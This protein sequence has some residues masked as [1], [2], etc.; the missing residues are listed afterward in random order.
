MP[1]G[2]AAGAQVAAVV[3]AASTTLGELPVEAEGVGIAATDEV[4][5]R[6]L[7]VSFARVVPQAGGLAAA[8]IVFLSAWKSGLRTGKRPRLDRT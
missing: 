6:P 5:A 4:P 8:D 7:C 1:G 2:T 3:G